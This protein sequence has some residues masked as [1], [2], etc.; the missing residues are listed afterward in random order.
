MCVGPYNI[1]D[2]NHFLMFPHSEQVF[3]AISILVK[4][5]LDKEEWG[6]SPLHLSP[7]YI[8]IVLVSFIFL[9]FLH[10]PPQYYWVL[11]QSHFSDCGSIYLLT[12]SYT[13]SPLLILGPEYTDFFVLEYLLLGPTF[14]NFLDCFLNITYKVS[15]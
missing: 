5:A 9:V 2:K 1:D 4:A 7:K 3:F 10:P 12:V 14:I 15:C 8:L 13:P 11:T 6:G